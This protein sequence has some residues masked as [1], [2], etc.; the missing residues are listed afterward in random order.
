MGP[1][2]HPGGWKLGLTKFVY[3][4]VW[5]DVNKAPAMPTALQPTMATV[6]PSTRRTVEAWGAWLG[7]GDVN[8]YLASA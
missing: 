3:Q 6:V 2:I 1:K 4:G 8:G 7:V 5:V